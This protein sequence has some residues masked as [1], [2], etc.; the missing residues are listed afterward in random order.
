MEYNFLLIMT[1]TYQ[2]LCL[3]S[4][5][6][7][8]SWCFHEYTLDNDV[9]EIH[10]T[11]FQSAPDD[12]HPSITVCFANPYQVEKFRKYQKNEISLDE[13]RDFQS[14]YNEWI[15]GY[16]P[17][18]EVVDERTL[19]RLNQ[20]DYDEV[21]ISLTDIIAEFEVK[22]TVDLETI[23]HFAYRVVNNSLV[24]D[25]TISSITTPFNGPNRINSY[26]STSRST[27]KCFTFD[28]PYKGHPEIKEVMMRLNAS[29]FPW[30][31]NPRQFYFTL[32]YPKQFLRTSLGSRIHLT[33]KRIS[34]C[35]QF[36]VHVGAMEVLTRR[37]KKSLRCN[38]DWRNQD[39]KHLLD[40]IDKIGCNPKHWKIESPLPNCS[41]LKQHADAKKELYQN[42]G[43]MPPCRSIE[44]LAKTVTG[45]K[46]HEIE[47][48]ST[49][50]GYLDVKFYFDEESTYKEIIRVPAY[51]LQSLIGNAGKYS[52][53]ISK[54]LYYRYFN[55]I[56][57]FM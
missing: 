53:S 15:D 14:T 48:R 29:I 19:Q 47:C 9:T 54:K 2:C 43:F 36:D 37:N 39:Q 49:P 8:V 26:A 7:L 6:V 20:I 46:V 41:N 42:D 13:L 4:A 17:G 3:I 1:K 35:Y 32:T 57:S 40:I 34:R 27:L 56:I 10:L 51:T 33:A 24:L 55:D 18:Q 5:I 22:V 12:I 30:G 21:T 16:L 52:Q 25:K 50:Y 44:K 38:E 23:D 31:L 11:K 28:V 45:K